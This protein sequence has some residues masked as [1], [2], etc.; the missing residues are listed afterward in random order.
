[1]S[2]PLFIWA[3]GK[4]KMIK[5]Y[6]KILPKPVTGVSIEEYVEPFFGGGGMFVHMMNK[7]KPKRVY[8]N[9]INKDVMSIYQC[10][11]DNYEEF[12]E[13]VE[14]LE[15]EYI[16][17]DKEGRRKFFFDVRHAHAFDYEG[18]SKPYE[19][20]T[21]YFLMKTAFNGIYQINKNTNNRYGTPCGLLN[22]KTEIFDRDVMKWWNVNLQNVNIMSGDWKDVPILENAFYFLDP[23]YRDSFADYGN[24]FDDDKLLELIKF[25]NERKN[26]FLCNRDGDDK[27]FEKN[28]LDMNIEKFDIT[29]T[30]G[31]RKKTKNGYEAKKAKEVLLWKTK[32]Y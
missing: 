28:K 17:K 31:R 5:H 13:R 32:D 15:K 24:S 16:P 9:D 6:D 7:Y 2:K 11:K 20:G 18:W 4:R 22:H 21:L 30:A 23:P 19:S 1:M 10:V 29:Y 8:I 12:I 3:G 27:F 26:V 25:S 14:E